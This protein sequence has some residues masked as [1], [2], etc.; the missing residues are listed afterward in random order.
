MVGIIRP[1]PYAV[2]THAALQHIGADIAEERIGR[3][4]G[5][6]T[7]LGD[8]RGGSLSS[9]IVASRRA[10]KKNGTDSRSVPAGG[11][12]KRCTVARR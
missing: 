9:G 2:R 10:E 11:V 7:H 6:S 12:T 5:G 8:K 4:A 3:I 1:L